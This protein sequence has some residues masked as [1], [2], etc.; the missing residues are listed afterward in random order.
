MGVV[1]ILKMCILSTQ[2]KGMITLQTRLCLYL[3]VSDQPRLDTLYIVL[4]TLRQC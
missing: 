2:T 4:V 1:K 3:F